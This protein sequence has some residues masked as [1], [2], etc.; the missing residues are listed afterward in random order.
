MGSS[1]F[2]KPAPNPHTH[3]SPDSILGVTRPFGGQELSRSISLPS[4]AKEC[5]TGDGE[6][7]MCDDS[8]SSGT[9]EPVSKPITTQHLISSLPTPPLPLSFDFNSEQRKNAMGNIFGVSYY[10]VLTGDNCYL[11]SDL[12]CLYDSQEL[13]FRM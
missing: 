5:G 4:Y 9:P 1:M 7:V 13:Q 3:T 6:L 2:V 10:T 12:S 11:I 8:D